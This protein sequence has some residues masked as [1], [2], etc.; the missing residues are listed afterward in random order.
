M[1]AWAGSPA[2]RTRRARLGGAWV[3]GGRGRYV[4][5]RKHVKPGDHQTY[6]ER[7]CNYYG[8]SCCTEYRYYIA[9][10]EIIDK[11]GE[12]VA[13]SATATVTDLF[14]TGNWAALIDGEKSPRGGYYRTTMRM[15]S[16]RNSLKIDLGRVVDISKV[17]VYPYASE[18]NRGRLANVS[19]VITESDDVPG[20]LDES[21]NCAAPRSVTKIKG[22]LYQAT[23]RRTCG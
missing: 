20:S 2:S 15:H 14:R 7:C 4:I 16:P 11:N 9:E 3:A 5:V 23:P 10:L 8:N 18:E 13:I 6:E 22:G 12:N 1:G 21:Q 19:I 17:I